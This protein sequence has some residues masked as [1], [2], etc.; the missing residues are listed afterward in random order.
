MKQA[1]INALETRFK[2]TALMLINLELINIEEIG[3]G[4]DKAHILFDNKHFD[5]CKKSLDILDSI[6]VDILEEK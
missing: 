1:E 6:I 4:I 5:T 3:N 2:S